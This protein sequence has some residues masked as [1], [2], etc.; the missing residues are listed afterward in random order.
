MSLSDVR[1]SIVQLQLSVRLQRNGMAMEKKNGRIAANITGGPQA[2]G[3]YG[4]C[5]SSARQDGVLL[6]RPV[7]EILFA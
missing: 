4:P 1:L 6:L 3:H 7:I 2:T 5:M